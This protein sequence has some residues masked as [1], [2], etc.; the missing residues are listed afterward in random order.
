M[1]QST[2]EAINLYLSGVKKGNPESLDLLYHAVS[3]TIRYIALKYL[4]NSHDADDLV[5]DFWADIHKIAAKFVFIDNGFS[6]LCKVMNR[7]ALNRYKKLYRER[8][9]E[10]L[11]VDYEAVDSRSEC[12][13]YENFEIIQSVENAIRNLDHTE[14][15]I[16]QLTIFEDKTIRAV[17]NELK[18]SK[19]KVGKMKLKA[20]EKI[21][22]EL[23]GVFGDKETD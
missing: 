2:K 18:M 6:Y 3:P 15:I 7:R 23:R 4:K 13:Y 1:D 21:K 10:V 20:M 17:A 22:E 16:V 5:Q 14:R 8:C 12:Y 19:S 11:Y 9:R